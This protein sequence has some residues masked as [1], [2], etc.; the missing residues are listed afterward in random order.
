MGFHGRFRHIAHVHER[1]IFPRK[2]YLL[3]KGAQG[4]GGL[5]KGRKEPAQG[6]EAVRHFFAAFHH[7]HPFDGIESVIEK[8]GV[9]L[10]S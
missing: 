2:L 1:H 5:E 7:S 4:I 6:G 10:V 3:P 9:D 8:M